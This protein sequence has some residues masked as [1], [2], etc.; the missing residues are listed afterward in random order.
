[1]K[2]T[3]TVKG[4]AYP[5]VEPY[6]GAGHLDVPVPCPVCADKVA[7]ILEGRAVA[8]AGPAGLHMA[9]LEFPLARVEDHRPE[10]LDRM[11]V[12]G[13]RADFDDREV[14]APAE[15]TRCRSEVG[16]IRVVYDT[17]FGAEED[18]RVTGG[19]WRVY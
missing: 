5:G 3:V 10:L 13:F 1:M 16:S 7:L 11:Q 8:L 18:A 9:R 15:C 17:L 14:N 12:R 19:I 6:P 4:R 2:I